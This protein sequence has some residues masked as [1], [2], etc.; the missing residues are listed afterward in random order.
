MGCATHCGAPSQETGVESRSP[1]HH[2]GRLWGFRGCGDH[3][4]HVQGGHACV[5]HKTADAG[6][7]HQRCR[8]APCVL[9]FTFCQFIPSLLSSL[10]PC[11][12]VVFL[13]LHRRGTSPVE[14]CLQNVSFLLVLD[15]TIN[16]EFDAFLGCLFR[17]YTLQFI[18]LT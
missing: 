4:V 2:P 18:Q 13:T 10:S 17:S 3:F 16:V 5:G 6:R 7:C 8:V 12:R 14:S 1:G 11:S 15:C 9:G